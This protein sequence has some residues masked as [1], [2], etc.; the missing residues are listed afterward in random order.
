MKFLILCFS[1]IG[2][3][4]QASEALDF[5]QKFEGA[6]ELE[7]AAGAYQ[8]CE[9][10]FA[11]WPTKDYETSIR[12]L[13]YYWNTY[14]EAARYALNTCQTMWVS[15]YLDPIKLSRLKRSFNRAQLAYSIA[16]LNLLQSYERMREEIRLYNEILPPSP[17]RIPAGPYEILSGLASS[18]REL[19][20]ALY[21]E[22]QKAYATLAGV[23]GGLVAALASTKS[24]LDLTATRLQ[25]ASRLLKQVL[26]IGVAAWGASEAMEYGMWQAR[27]LELTQRLTTIKAQLKNAEGVGRDILVEEFYRASERLG[28]FYDFELYLRESGQNA[29]RSSPKCLEDVSAFFSGQTSSILGRFNRGEYC[30]GAAA[31][32]LGAS[33]FLRNN[34]P[35]NVQAKAAADRLL[36]KAK[37]AYWSDLEVLIY[38]A[39][40]PRCDL[41]P[42]STM[43]I[44]PIYEC[45]DPNT[46]QITF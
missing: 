40:R 2:F 24:F 34:F 12:E 46:G 35:A 42:D 11:T 43:L 13:G 44:S 41:I 7:R 21:Q 5:V 23:G 36:A 20:E 37:K 1:L 25:S 18:D 29:P 8:L 38:R 32:W 27:N 19:S 31:V 4:A 17:N 3:S 9:R 10:I 26:L 39:E 45:R 33:L 15:K 14:P 28:Y 6:Q 30:Q 16:S 22:R